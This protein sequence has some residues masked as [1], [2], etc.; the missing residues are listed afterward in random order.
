MALYL[1]SIFDELHVSL[2]YATLLYED[3]CGALLMAH[4]GQPT[5][6][7]RHIDIHHYALIDWVECDLIALEDVAS[8]PNAADAVTKQTGD[9]LFA[10]HVDNITGCFPPP[11][12]S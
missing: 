7:S 1:H 10:R 2:I 5:K 8:G 6:Q 11:Y 12:I 4:A 9:I 3:N